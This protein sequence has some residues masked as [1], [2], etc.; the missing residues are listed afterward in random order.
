MAAKAAGISV[1][2]VM[3]VRTSIKSK[4]L[5]DKYGAIGRYE[6]SIL[7]AGLVFF[8]YFIISSQSA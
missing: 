3:P 1:T 5:P 2:I 7:K 6:H 8:I 4:R